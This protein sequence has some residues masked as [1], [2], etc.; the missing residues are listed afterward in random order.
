M[1]TLGEAVSL[2][3]YVGDAF[4]SRPIVYLVSTF[5]IP[6]Q[7]LL[8]RVKDAK[9]RYWRPGRMTIAGVNCASG[10]QNGKKKK[11]KWL[12]ASQITK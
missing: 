8:G 11:K 12:R 2:T 5:K 9:G 3:C 6:S 7:R 4:A 1:V 10:K